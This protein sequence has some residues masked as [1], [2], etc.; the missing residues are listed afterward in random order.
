MLDR[1]E[2]AGE[3]HLQHEQEVVE[4]DLAQRLEIAA[5]EDAGARHDAVEPAERVDGAPD[6]GRDIIFVPTSA[7]AAIA[8]PPADVIFARR[9]PGGIGGAV[10]H[11][12]PRALRGRGSAARRAP[13]AARAAG[14]EHAPRHESRTLPGTV[15]T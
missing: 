5:V 1:K 2:G 9:V 15:P 14:D 12:H 3:V 6:R 4:R 7:G 13:D 8:L 10:D 11:R